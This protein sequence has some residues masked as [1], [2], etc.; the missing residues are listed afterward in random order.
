M[1]VEPFQGLEVGEQAVRLSDTG[2][3]SLKRPVLGRAKGSRSGLHCPAP[4]ARPD[5]RGVCTERLAQI[6]QLLPNKAL[7]AYG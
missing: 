7:Q 2:S 6:L 1:E 5:P 3:I 4:T